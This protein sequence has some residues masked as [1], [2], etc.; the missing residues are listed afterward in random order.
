MAVLWPMIC[1][2]HKEVPL[3]ALE[4]CMDHQ[5]PVRPSLL[6]LILWRYEVHAD[7]RYCDL[8]MAL[9]ALKLIYESNLIHFFDL[10]VGPCHSDRIR[11]AFT[12]VI[13]PQ[14][15]GLLELLSS[16]SFA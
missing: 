15:F 6:G 16:N 7:F 1:E 9:K 2:I 11:P 3:S 10:H 14:S 8:C 13:N 4:G 12:L 5:R